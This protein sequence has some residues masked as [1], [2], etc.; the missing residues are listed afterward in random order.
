[1]LNEFYNYIAVTVISFFQTRRQSIKPGERF[2]LRLDTEEM[3]KGVYNALHERLS[4]DSTLGTYRFGDVYVTDTFRLSPETEIVIAAKMDGITDDFMATLRN[5]KRTENLWP[6]LVLTNLTIDSVSTSTGDLSSYGMPFHED[7]IRKRI[8]ECIQTA[9]F[10]PAHR[11]L[12]ELELDRKKEDRFGDK[13]SLYEYCDLLTVLEKGD[14][15]SSDFHAFSLLDDP[16]ILSVPESQIVNRVRDNHRI[17]DEISR[18]YENGDMDDLLVDGYGKEFVERLKSAR[19]RNQERWYEGLTFNIVNAARHPWKEPLLIENQ[20]IQIHSASSP[21]YSFLKKSLAFI[22]NDGE[23]KAKRRKKNILIFNPDHEKEIV[24]RIRCNLTVRKSW[25]ESYGAN[26]SSVAKNVQITIQANGCAFAYVAIQDAD[27]PAKYLFKICVIDLPARYLENARSVFLLHIPKRLKKSRIELLGLQNEFAVNPGCDNIQSVTLKS[28]ETYDCSYEQT[29]H[30]R[31]DEKAINPDTGRLEFILRCGSIQMPLRILDEPVKPTPMTG[32]HAFLTKYQPFDRLEYREGK[33]VSRAQEFVPD[34]ASSFQEDLELETLFIKNGWP[35]IAADDNGNYEEYPL[36]VERRVKEAYL[37]FTAELKRRNQP[38]SLAYYDGDLKAFAESYVSAVERSLE[39]IQAGNQLS[40]SENHLLLL[41]CVVAKRAISMSPLHPLN[42]AYQLELLEQRQV[43]TVRKELVEKLNP[44]Y[45]LPYFRFRHDALYC[46]A[47]QWRAPKREFE[48][49]HAPE[50]RGYVPMVDGRV[51]GGH[52]FVRKLVCEKIEQYKEHFRFLFDNLSNNQCC[53]SL[54]H[55]GDCGEVAQGLIR[56]FARAFRKGLS[57]P[58]NGDNFSIYVYDNPAFYHSNHFYALTS[59]SLIR[60]YIFRNCK[61]DV[62]D[63]EVSDVALMFGS[64]VKCYFKDIREKPYQYAHLCFYEMALSKDGWG[65]RMDKIETGI[66]LGGLVSS[67]PSE[68]DGEWYKTGFGMKYAPKNRLTELAKRYNALSNVAFSGSSYDPLQV[69]FTK[70]AGRNEEL[71]EKIYQASNWVVFIDPKVDL[72]FF[73]K[74]ANGQNLT[75]VHYSDQFTSSSGYDDITVTQKTRQYEEIIRS[76]LRKKGVDANSKNVDEIIR[77][78]NAVNGDWMLRLISAKKAVGAADSNF[79]RE[80]LSVLSAM[81]L[82]MAYY[83][84]EKI[85]WIPISLEEM[86]RVSGGAGYSQKDGLLSAK[87]LGFEKGVKSDDLLMVGMERASG[88]LRIYLHPVEVKIGKNSQGTIQTAKEQV[89]RTMRGLWNA[90]WPEEHRD[91]LEQKLSRNFF[92]QYVIGCCK[93][94]KLYGMNPRGQWDSILSEFREKLLNDEYE[95][96]PALERFIGKGSVVSFKSDIFSKSGKM[97]DDVCLLEFPEKSGAEYLVMSPDAIRR[98]LESAAQTFPERLKS[99]GSFHETKVVSAQNLAVSTASSLSSVG[100]GGEIASEVIP[101]QSVNAHIP[102]PKQPP[103]QEPGMRIQFGADVANGQPVYWFPNHTKRLFHVNTGIIG[104][105]GTGKT[106]FTQ[107]IVAQMYR[108]QKHNLDGA[109]LGILIFDYKGD[110]NESKRDF[111]KATKAVVLKPYHLPFNPLSLAKSNVFRPLLPIHTANAFKDT[112]SKVYGLGPKQQNA[113]LSCIADAYAECGII[114]EDADTWGNP[115][116]TFERVY[117]IY[118]DNEEIKKGDSLSV[119]ME[120]L[121]SFQIF[122]GDSQ[123]TVSLFETLNGV[124][125]IDLSGYN[126]DLQSLIVA[127]TLDLFYAQMQAAGSSKLDGLYRQL[128]KMILVDEADNFMSEGFPSLKKILKEGRE[129]GVG[130]ILSTQFLKHFSS[131]DDD[132]AKYILTWIVHNVPDLK[133]SDVEFVFQR[134]AKD[135]KTQRLLNG[136]KALNQHCSI[137]KI[138]NSEPQY[139]R[140]KAFW[141]FYADLTETP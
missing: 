87:N 113:L 100:R 95:F 22:R 35:A 65:L 131:G 51:C 129:F 105:M 130:V 41:G 110:Y 77:L 61:E 6:I 30:L 112:L 98:D 140:D 116:P 12:L 132:Y 57:S 94:M 97:E 85:I 103:S 78:F 66:S 29:L 59:Q 141:E 26:C 31:F 52:S 101:S 19:K 135:P 109:P 93:K 67:L 73:S 24:I 64:H 48:E 5:V 82:C 17:F 120:Q 118:Q 55:M 15:S 28:G 92:M 16:D 119:V 89:L 58:E 127:I 128:T 75:I 125:V 134:D 38:P 74:E 91:C 8:A 136:I 90:L 69:A 40:P 106:Q 4:L 96:S 21:E 23:T 139:M 46:A 54:I 7:S 117:R 104:A 43:G 83:E 50:W 60:E 3:V 44:L 49:R 121:H 80:K 39:S 72:S 33:I 126:P 71:L 14:I 2:V 102:N 115:P 37:N 47:E 114:P 27:N 108:E 45:L 18:I 32:I 81:K 122:E 138:G 84:H 111:Q 53:I 42:V 20:D 123:K 79:S 34:S 63:D 137:V 107:S 9:Q 25:L 36:E 88:V 56:F 99:I 11:K 10:L 62:K 13:S 133:M 124:V 70:I 76:Q 86:L 68:L 1:M